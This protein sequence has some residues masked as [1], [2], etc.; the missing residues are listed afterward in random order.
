MPEPGAL[1]PDVGT[2][3][4]TTSFLRVVILSGVRRSRGPH[5]QVFVRGVEQR[6]ESKDLRLLFAFY[7]GTASNLAGEFVSDL[8]GGSVASAPQISSQNQ[9]ALQAAEELFRWSTKCQ[10]TTGAPTQW[11][12]RVP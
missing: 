9:G 3:D 6:T 2:S 4:T 8:H 12:G 1:C 7:R 11:V 5:G 10:G